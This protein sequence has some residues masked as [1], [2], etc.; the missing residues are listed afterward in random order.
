MNKPDYWN[1]AKIILSKRDKVMKKLIDNYKDGT[2]I[3]RNDVFLSDLRI[4][5]PQK[6][7]EPEL[8]TILSTAI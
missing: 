4:F 7:D 5:I 8:F 6:K 1:K 2:L 3:T